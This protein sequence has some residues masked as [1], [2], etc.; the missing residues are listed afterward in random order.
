MCNV[1]NQLRGDAEDAVNKPWRPLP[2]GRIT[3]GQA[4]AL[5]WG[6]VAMCAWCSS[7]CGTD[8]VLVTLTLF[9]TTLLYDDMGLA[10]H[11]V[12]KNF[13]NIGGYT[14]FEIGATKLM[15]MFTIRRDNGA[16]HS[17]Y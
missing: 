6:T 13:C 3:G 1:S 15:G 8:L 7:A 12:G 5:R 2:A 10:A 9:T 4:I 14:T 11:H 17:L 16:L